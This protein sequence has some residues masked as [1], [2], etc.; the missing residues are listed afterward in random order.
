M[1]IL[2]MD[3]S[4]SVCS[5]A[6]AQ[7]E[8]IVAFAYVDNGLTHSAL[9]MPRIDACLCEA[10]LTVA[11]MD[12]FAVS[13]GPGSFTGLRIGVT[14]AKAFAQAMDKPIAAFDTLAV[15]AT[16]F[17]DYAGLVCPVINAR[18]NRVYAAL[19][20]DGEL[21]KDSA[22]VEVAQ[23]CNFVGNESVLFCGDGIDAYQEELM[24]QCKKA[25]FAPSHM[26]YQRADALIHLA[27]GASAQK[28][29]YTAFDVELTYLVESQAERM[30]KERQNEG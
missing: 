19:Y 28:K 14:T 12:L 15:L 26:R 17:V 24:Q 13:A 27:M 6:V 22:V 9:L 11:D 25:I 5:V 21:L 16:N 1:N 3:T 29:V 20:E 18:N 4:G 2:A 30:L 8:K 7:G 10:G 23:I